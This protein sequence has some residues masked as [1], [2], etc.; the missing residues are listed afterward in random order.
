MNGIDRPEDRRHEADKDR[1]I[2]ELREAVRARDEFV[3]IAAQLASPEMVENRPG[4]PV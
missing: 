2:Q 4:S 1:L 3:S